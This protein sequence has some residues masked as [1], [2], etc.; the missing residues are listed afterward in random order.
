MRPLRV[1]PPLVALLVS[2]CALAQPATPELTAAMATATA[3]VGRVIASR[4]EAAPMA[5]SAFAIGDDL[6]L[7]AA[8]VAETSRTVSVRF[9]G[10]LPVL[11]DAIGEDPTRDVLLLRAREP[12]GVPGLRLATAGA[13]SGDLLGLLGY[14]DAGGG[15]Q[16]Q[17]ARLSETGFGTSFR[18]ADQQ[19]LR[20]DAES[21]GGN[22][23]G[24]VI[25]SAGS[26][27]GLMVAVISSL[28][29]GESSRVVTLA[30]PAAD[31]AERA[32]RWRAQ[33]SSTSVGQACPGDENLA[34]DPPELTVIGTDQLTA[35]VAQVIWLAL[36]GWNA[37]EWHSAAQQYT[38]SGQAD[39][40]LAGDA[41]V[42][43]W[44]RAE[45]SDVTS[46]EDAAAAVVST[47]SVVEGHCRSQQWRYQLRFAQGAWL[48]DSIGPA[49]DATAC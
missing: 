10:R 41:P 30:V 28:R 12:L 42:V 33:P 18:G 15:V 31:V 39:L 2:G 44:L 3:S 48:I 20:L 8:H 5:G 21:A 34:H 27:Q 32:A 9:P 22:S 17:A 43:Q 1:L 23:G 19:F 36:S 45:V 11:A 24:T 49:G 47:R 46:T 16:T 38:A 25:D 6:I 14:P 35:E 40:G 4:C 29:L 37:G 26:V 7:T 13:S